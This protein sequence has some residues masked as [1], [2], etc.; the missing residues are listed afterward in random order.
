V[1]LFHCITTCADCHVITGVTY[2]DK[3][4]YYYQ[5]SGIIVL[6]VIISEYAIQITIKILQFILNQISLQLHIY[7][8]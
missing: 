6:E 5:G 8:I 4:H 2:T 3:Y 7:F 1:T